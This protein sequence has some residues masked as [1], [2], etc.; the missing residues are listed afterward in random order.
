MRKVKIALFGDHSVGKTSLIRRFAD[1]EFNQDTLPTLQSEFISRIYNYE[2]VNYQIQIYDTAGQEKFRSSSYAL[3]HAV[4]GVILVYDITRRD[5]FTEIESILANIPRD[6][7]IILVGNKSDLGNDRE[8]STEEGTRFANEHDL[9][10]FETSAEF[11]SNVVES[12][13]RLIQMIRD[14]PPTEDGIQLTEGNGNNSN[15]KKGCC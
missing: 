3:T 4:Q 10:F 9:P 8:V 14:N 13:E 6:R 1:D 12:F 15:Q 2:G 11:V 7:R 5:S